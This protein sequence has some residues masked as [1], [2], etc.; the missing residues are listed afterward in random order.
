MDPTP[1]IAD[2]TSLLSQATMLLEGEK[3]PS[4]R[5]HK[6]EE[7]V[8]AG[9]LISY[10]DNGEGVKGVENTIATPPPKGGQLYDGKPLITTYSNGADLPPHAIKENHY[11]MNGRRKL[12]M[13]T[14]RT[15]S[16]G[17]VITDNTQ[18]EYHSNGQIARR[19]RRWRDG[20]E[21]RTDIQTFDNQGNQTS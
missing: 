11:D 7:L 14:S 16:G 10:S 13:K 17:W 21:W 19:E 2:Q 20:G 8:A 9:K 6:L 1:E 18:I 5:L 4:N 3:V 15:D 12:I